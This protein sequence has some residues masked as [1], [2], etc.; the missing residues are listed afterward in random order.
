M[1]TR[2]RLR[3]LLIGVTLLAGAQM[4]SAPV[5]HAARCTPWGKGTCTACKNCRY[6]GHCAKNGGVCSVCK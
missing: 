3:A 5:A 2:F 6:C 4:A 1:L